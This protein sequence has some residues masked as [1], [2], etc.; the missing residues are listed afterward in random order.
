[1]NPIVFCIYHNKC[2]DGLMAAAVVKR[3]YPD[4]EFFAANYNEPAPIESL[5]GKHCIIVDFSYSRDVTL[6]I[7]DASAKLLVL[8]HHKTAQAA[9][10]DIDHAK[11]K[12]I[13]DMERSGAGLAWDTFYPLATGG[14]RPPLINMV[15][16][17][18]LWRFQHEGSQRL[19]Y[20]LTCMEPTPD[21][22][23]HQLQLSIQN[24][25]YLVDLVGQG[26]AMEKLFAAQIETL[27]HE[28]FTVHI[29]GYVVPVVNAPYIFASDLAGALAEGH[30]FAATYFFN[31]KE[32]VWSLRS[33]GE[34]SIDVSD[35]AQQYG[36]GGH[37]HAAGF[38]CHV[39]SIIQ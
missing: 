22:F 37:K 36:G 31:G 2:I 29:S 11:A 5:K 19:H 1:M 33:R 24:P 7:A 28:A 34:N 6:Q 27:K 14:A 18:D 16:D 3:T 13:F 9:L 17:R 26:A 25:D 39:G 10:A 38:K 8:D 30:P 23:A 21:G 12:I 4:A 32:E 20:V 15:E 35:I